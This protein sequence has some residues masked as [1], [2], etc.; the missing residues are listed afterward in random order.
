VVH[1]TDA[2]VKVSLAGICGSDLHP[3]HGDRGN[4]GAQLCYPDVPPVQLLQLKR[5][6]DSVPGSNTRP[7]FDWNCSF[8]PDVQGVREG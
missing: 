4:G 1:P 5:Y 7:S 8:S 3:F 6:L 2:V